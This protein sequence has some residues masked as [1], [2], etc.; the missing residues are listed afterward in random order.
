MLTFLRRIGLLRLKSAFSVTVMAPSLK[1]L[2]TDDLLVA[3]TCFT[4]SAGAI[5][6]DAYE[7]RQLR[8]SVKTLSRAKRK[9]RRARDRM[10]KQRNR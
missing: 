7:G 10:S 8:L 9:A 6:A 1:A 5:P 4:R 3:L 2:T